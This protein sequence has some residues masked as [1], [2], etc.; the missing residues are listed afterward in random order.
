MK[1]GKL[2]FAF[3]NCRFLLYYL[4]SLGNNNILICTFFKFYMGIFIFMLLLALNSDFPVRVGAG[5]FY[6][7]VF[8]FRIRL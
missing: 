5:P 1:T 7:F 3:V 2:L 8:L 6:Q 4:R